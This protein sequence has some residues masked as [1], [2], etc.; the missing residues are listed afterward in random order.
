M[1]CKEKNLTNETKKTK[2][3]LADKEIF[4]LLLIIIK[5]VDYF[6]NKY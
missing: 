1:Y 5:E 3:K 6:E 4:I 2:I